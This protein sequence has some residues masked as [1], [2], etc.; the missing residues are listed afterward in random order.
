MLFQH[1]V[2]FQRSEQ[3]E[4]ATARYLKVVKAALLDEHYLENEVRLE[5]L[6][7]TT[8]S[9]RRSPDEAARPGAPRAA[10]VPPARSPAPRAGRPGAGAAT[11]FLPFTAMG[12]T[13]LDHLHRCLDTI[14]DES[15]GGDLIECGTGRGGG[16]IFMRA[17]LDA[18]ELPE[19]S[20]FVADR[21]RSSP[22]PATAPRMPRRASRA[23]GPISTSCATG[24]RG[25]ISSTTGSGSSKD[26]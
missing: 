5:L 10:G 22:E 15:V 9:A 21:F 7:A 18:W 23:S 8:S 6:S 2:F 3:V 24:S 12:R 14:R 16:A 20:V 4:R 1:N 26:R 17:Y 13:Q 25:S 11:S 19:R